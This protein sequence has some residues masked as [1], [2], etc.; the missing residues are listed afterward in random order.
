MRRLQAL[1]IVLVALAVTVSVVPRASAEAIDTI[2]TEGYRIQTVPSS[3]L[4]TAR[5]ISDNGMVVLFTN[6]TNKT[7]NI[8][9]GIGYPFSDI[10]CQFCASNPNYNITGVNS[11]DVFA[12]SWINGS[13][14]KIP[15]IWSESAGYNQLGLPVGSMGIVGAEVKGIDEAGNIAG[16]FNALPGLCDDTYSGTCSFFGSPN[17]I[18]GYDY[19]VIPAMVSATNIGG[20]RVVG[21]GWTWTPGGGM[22]DLR[23]PGY[24]VAV[25]YDVNESGEIAGILGDGAGNNVAAYW[26]GPTASPIPIGTLSGDSQSFAAAINGSGQVVGWSGTSQSP[27]DPRR[28]FAWTPPS[29]PMVD[30]GLLPGGATAEAW[31]INLAGLVA[32][33][34]D[35]RPVIWDFA[36]SGYDIDYPPEVTVNGPGQ[37]SEGDLLVIDLTVTDFDGDPFTVTLSGEPTGA[38]WDDVSQ[39]ITWQTGPGDAGTYRFSVTVAQDDQP[40]NTL[41]VPLTFLVSGPLTLDPIGDQLATEGELLTFT[42]TSSAGLAQ[43][44]AVGGT[45]SNPTPLPPGAQINPLTGVFTWTPDSSQVGDHEITIQ[46]TDVG[47]FTRPTASETITITVQ[48]AGGAQPVTIMVDESILVIDDPSI[49]P[50]ALIRLIEGIRVSDDVQVRPPI[51]ISVFENVGVSDGGGVVPSALIHF[52]ESVNVHDA[53]VVSP[54]ALASLSGMKWEDIDGDGARDPGE[55]A[56]QGVSIYLDLDDDGTLDSGEPATVTAAD[57]SYS[58]DGLVP[59]LWV[60]REVVPS[61]YTQTFP[62]AAAG[63]EHQVTLAAE[64]L[65][66]GFDFGNQPLPNLAPIIQPID[67]VFAVVGEQIAVSPIVTDPEG[68]QFTHNWEG[69]PSNAIING[70]FDLTP[71]TAQGGSVFEITLTVT[72]DDDPSKTTSA[73]FKVYVAA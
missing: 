56:M 27:N 12:G 3:G 39:D 9:P 40:A 73:T 1:L 62:T 15:F 43:Y 5:L 55:P 6:Q 47:D 63:F 52:A 38:V 20:G 16:I 49:L 29:G 41:T 24:S 65:A 21:N 60:V 30:L 68:D 36:G 18:G 17:A 23:H 58:F 37:G 13:G 51:L 11:S 59:G 32:G 57:G 7:N 54:E 25:A 67:D 72:Q 45:P 42:A 71:T 33:T 44:V 35:G 61:G 10:G 48:P 66:T 26:P 31:D 46:V 53:V 2:S 70:I 64:D 19:D 34:A 14:V 50:S 8:W 28:A 22:L 69:A 4:G